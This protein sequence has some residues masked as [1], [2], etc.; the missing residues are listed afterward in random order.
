M[1]AA[2]APRRLFGSIRDSDLSLALADRPVQSPLCVSWP[3]S[4]SGC[5]GK[6]STP[7]LQSD[8]R[9]LGRKIEGF[10]IIT[11]DF[12]HQCRINISNSAGLFN[13]RD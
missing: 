6:L 9:D 3:Q 11:D 7:P 4:K 2:L 1:G 13:T 8:A 12:P 10:G 5:T